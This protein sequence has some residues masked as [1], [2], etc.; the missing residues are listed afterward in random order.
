MEELI[1]RIATEA[2]LEPGTAKKAIGMILA[3]LR[4]E[5]PKD[6]IDGLF[7]DLPG[8]AEAAAKRG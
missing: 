8:A 3:F 7:A 2:G 6:E 4:N 5:G 1:A